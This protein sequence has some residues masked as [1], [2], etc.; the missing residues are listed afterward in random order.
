MFRPATLSLSRDNHPIRRTRA[1]SHP[2]T[3]APSHRRTVAPAQACAQRLWALTNSPLLPNTSHNGDFRPQIPPIRIAI[4]DQAQLPSATPFL[5]LFLADYRRL[6][7]IV[8]LVIHQHRDVV[9]M[10]ET[11][12]QMLAVLPH[13]LHQVAGNAGVQGAVPTAGEDVT[14]GLLHRFER[15]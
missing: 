8:L 2:R 15:L 10:G 4:F 14:R 12:C 13:A 5:D 7:R 9:L 6:H 1:P 11:R 3:V